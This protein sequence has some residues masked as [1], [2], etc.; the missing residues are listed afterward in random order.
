MTYVTEFNE[1]GEADHDQ[2]KRGKESAYMAGSRGHKLEP[3]VISRY[4]C[5]L[6]TDKPEKLVRPV[7]V[8]PEKRRPHLP[9]GGSV[10]ERLGRWK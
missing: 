1:T 10:G 4:G 5:R 8:T 2:A 6:L 3:D 9:R 7:D